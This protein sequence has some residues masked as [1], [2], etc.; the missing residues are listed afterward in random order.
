MSK[1]D[2]KKRIWEIA[3]QL[4]DEGYELNRCDALM[5]HVIDRPFYLIWWI[6]SDMLPHLTNNC[7]IMSKLVCKASL[8]KDHDYRLKRKSFSHKVCVRCVLGI[9][10]DVNHVVMQCPCNE[11]IREEMLDVIKAIDVDKSTRLLSE[12]QNVFKT[13]MGYHPIDMPLEFMINV[14]VISS[15]YIADMYRQVIRSRQ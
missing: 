3:W 11:G 9:R 8:L 12:P 1:L 2:W 7:E 14:W 10:E 6:I 13:L 15:K 4:E 5:F